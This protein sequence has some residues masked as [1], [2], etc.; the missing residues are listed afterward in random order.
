MYEECD[1]SAYYRSQADMIR[2]LGEALKDAGG[3][4]AVMEWSSGSFQARVAIVSTDA[5]ETLTFTGPPELEEFAR[6]PR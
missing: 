5:Q 2:A 6:R 3:G 4:N 1:S